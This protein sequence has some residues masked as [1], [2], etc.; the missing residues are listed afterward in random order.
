MGIC[1]EIYIATEK[2]GYD[3]DSFEYLSLQC[4]TDSHL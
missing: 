1:A 3:K 2:G 4:A